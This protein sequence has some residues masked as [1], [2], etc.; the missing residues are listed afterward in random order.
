MATAVR[1][2]HDGRANM[3]RPQNEPDPSTYLG[4]VAK[5]LKKLRE[6]VDMDTEK[7]AEAITRAGYEVSAGTVYRWERGDTQPHVEAIPAIAKAYRL[8]SSRLVL[9]LE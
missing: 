9:P 7:A 3:P 8:S 6:Q 2:K 4:R 5:R 1:M